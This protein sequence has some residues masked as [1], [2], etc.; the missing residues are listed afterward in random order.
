MEWMIV[1]GK[2][3]ALAVLLYLWLIMPRM[4][5]R[6]SYQAVLARP[7]AHRGVHDNRTGRPENSLPAFARAVELGYGM[8]LDV[9]LTKDRVPVV[10][11]DSSLKRVCGVNR[12]LR[13]CTYAEIQAYR[14]F[15]TNCSIP[16]LQEVLT[17]VNGATPLLVEMKMDKTDK[18]LCPTVAP[19]LD[20]YKGVYCIESFNPIALRWYR[21]NRP[22]VVRGQL[23]TNYIKDEGITNPIFFFLT[24]LLTNFYTKP[25]FIAYNH[26]FKKDLS[27]RIC[28][29]LYRCM[30][31]A[32]TVTSPEE[33]KKCERDFDQFIFEGFKMTLQDKKEKV[34]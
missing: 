23:S 27:R 34:S 12:K 32:W 13:D 19:L 16:T 21:K 11:H 8:E 5:H 2:T 3:L 31:F 9:Q 4:R 7:Y 25:D 1:L 17:L 28:R 18:N 29:R 22:Q 6:P 30:N 33:L 15:G 26:L 10:F 20:V 14:L 24:H